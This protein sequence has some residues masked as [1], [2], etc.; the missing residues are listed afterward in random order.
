MQ[1]E[2]RAGSPG[3]A[4][5]FPLSKVNLLGRLR[6]VILGEAKFLIFQSLPNG[7]RLA[8]SDGV[9]EGDRANV[10]ATRTC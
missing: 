1:L 8:L 10:E 3:P 4:R 2:P 5:I 9:E 7:M 6:G